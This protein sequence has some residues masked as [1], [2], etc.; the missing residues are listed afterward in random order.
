VK[1]DDF[2]LTNSGKLMELTDFS[3]SASTSFSGG[4][5]GIRLNEQPH[6]PAHYNPLSQSIYNEMDPYFNRRPVQPIKSP[7]SFSINFRYSWNLNPRGE[8]RKRASINIQNIQFQLTPKWSFSTRFGYDIIAQELTPSQFSLNRKLHEW[9]LSFQMNP[10]GDFQYYLDRK[11]TRLN[12]SHVSISY[13]VF[14]LQ[15]K[16]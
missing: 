3:I 12:S 7:W 14:C 13:A 8:N 2:L 15:K 5:G 6:F 4:D 11:S 10:F 9:N 1:I 16:I